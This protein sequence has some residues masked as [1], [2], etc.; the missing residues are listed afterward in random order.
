LIKRFER[1][2]N[3]FASLN[4]I[5]IVK[6]SDWGQTSPDSMFRGAPFYV[7]EYL[8]GEGLGDRIERLGRLSLE[9][10]ALIFVQICAG[11]REA[12]QQGII[13]RDLKPDNIFLI[14]GG[15]SGELAKILDFG[16]A[17]VVNQDAEKTRLT[18]VGSFIG[19]YR[20]ASPEQCLG[21]DIDARSD[22]YS[23]GVVFY[24]MLSGTNPFKINLQIENTQGQWMNSHI[25]KTP[26][27]L[28][29]QRDCEDMPSE[30]G[31]VVMKCLE[32][33][34]ENRF[35]NVDELEQAL[36]AALPNIFRT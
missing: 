4:S 26:Q 33:L 29:S 10:A 9:E 3:V 32:K 31:D 14:A 13:H 25:N 35:A 7:M 8:E 27:L 19:T 22:L 24:E 36:K 21:G 2:V 17:K 5:N 6:V 12:H 30:L 23:L 28:K 20:Y 18:N 16:I 15:P 34:P 1:E 11:L